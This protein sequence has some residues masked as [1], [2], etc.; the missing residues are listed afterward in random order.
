MQV[1]YSFE[2]DGSPPG[3][4]MTWLAPSCLFVSVEKS[5]SL[6]RHLGGSAQKESV[7]PLPSVA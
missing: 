7:K 2:F 6:R 5:I 3:F 1:F 4:A